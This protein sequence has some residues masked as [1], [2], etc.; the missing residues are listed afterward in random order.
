VVTV[1]V[2]ST[3][4]GTF[5]NCAANLAGITEFVPSSACA[6]VDLVAALPIVP[7]PPSPDRGAIAIAGARTLV[8]WRLQLSGGRLGTRLPIAAQRRR[9]STRVR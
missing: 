6:S 9:R 3:V 4:A 8:H 7:T 2:T 5:T 1:A